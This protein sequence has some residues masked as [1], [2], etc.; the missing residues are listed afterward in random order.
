MTKDNNNDNKNTS[1]NWAKNEEWAIDMARAMGWKT[2][3]EL[4]LEPEDVMQQMLLQAYRAS[5]NC[6][7]GKDPRPYM[8][9][10][11]YNVRK[12]IIRHHYTCKEKFNRGCK[13]LDATMDYDEEDPMD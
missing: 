4:G 11:C 9:V 8:V 10:S 5:V 2:A 7:P 6:A 12:Q 1:D 13:R 3:K